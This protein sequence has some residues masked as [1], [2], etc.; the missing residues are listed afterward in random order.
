MTPS[1]LRAQAQPENA[2]ELARAA[3]RHP[4]VEGLALALVSMEALVDDGHWTA[5]VTMDGERVTECDVYQ[6]QDDVADLR[7]RLRD[8]CQAYK[9]LIVC[10]EDIETDAGVGFCW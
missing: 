4:S 8:E 1:F 2:K 10:H 3:L 5:L 7:E 9:S 6:L